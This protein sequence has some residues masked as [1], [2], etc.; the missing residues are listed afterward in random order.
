[1]YLAQYAGCYKY[2]W[3]FRRNSCRLNQELKKKKMDLE[4]MKA[5]CTAQ[6][7]GQKSFEVE[8]SASVN[9]NKGE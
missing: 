6:L 3:S 7:G 8:T 2:T 9:E 5:L 4:S 1:M